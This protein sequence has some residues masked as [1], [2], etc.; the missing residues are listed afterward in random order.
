MNERLKRFFSSRNRKRGS[1]VP[2]L[3]NSSHVT[4]IYGGER[5]NLTWFADLGQKNS[6]T[7]N[8][9]T[10]CGNKLFKIHLKDSMERTKGKFV[11]KTQGGSPGTPIGTP[12]VITITKS[13]QFLGLEFKRPDGKGVVS[14][15]QKAVGYQIK[16]NGGRWQIIDS[17][18]RFEEVWHTDR[19]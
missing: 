9:I 17:W 12:D 1:A 18:E 4:A 14:P 2:G 8:A 3:L 15:E 16:Q 10:G 5:T 7:C 6:H 19:I 11:I 13:G